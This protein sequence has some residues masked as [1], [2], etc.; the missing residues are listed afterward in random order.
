MALIED[1]IEWFGIWDASMG[2][3][4]RV[5]LFDF[6]VLVFHMMIVEKNNIWYG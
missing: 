5:F 3:T 2:K 6:L 1:Y 4:C